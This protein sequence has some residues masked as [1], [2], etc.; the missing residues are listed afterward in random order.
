MLTATDSQ[1]FMYQFSL[2]EPK[3]PIQEAIL[4]PVSLWS[5]NA[6]SFLPQLCSQFGG[7]VRKT[8][9]KLLPP[10]MIRGNKHSS[11][12]QLRSV[13]G[14]SKEMGNTSHL[15]QEVCLP[16]DPADLERGPWSSARWP[17]GRDMGN[18]LRDHGLTK[19]CCP[20]DLQPLWSLIS[21][22]SF[23]WWGDAIL[24]PHTC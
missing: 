16:P 12:P 4:L 20:Q 2:P 23:F 1:C 21:A 11:L 24:W 22:S 18:S 5:L 6:A 19:D 3:C 10:F 13:P 15:Y 8:F 17:L 14:E 7:L 9:C